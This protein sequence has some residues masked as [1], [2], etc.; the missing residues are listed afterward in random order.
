MLSLGWV[1][2]LIFYV[3]G[4]VRDPGALNGNRSDSA[5]HE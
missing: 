5:I 4:V 3:P 1:S 2:L